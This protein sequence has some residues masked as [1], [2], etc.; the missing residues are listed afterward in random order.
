MVQKC[1]P[2]AAFPAVDSSRFRRLKPQ[3]EHC[4]VAI[5]DVSS[6]DGSSFSAHSFKYELNPISAYWIR[7][8]APSL[9]AVGT[10]FRDKT[11]P[12]ASLIRGNSIGTSV[13]NPTAYYWLQALSFPA[14]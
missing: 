9:A 2:P 6:F 5:R 11:P 3:Y 7:Q 13:I 14:A 4:L 1:A 8:L 10:R 12:R